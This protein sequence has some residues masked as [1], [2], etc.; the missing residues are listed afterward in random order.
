MNTPALYILYG[1]DD[2]GN[3]LLP[4]YWPWEQYVNWYNYFKEV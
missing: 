1:Q 2:F 4:A 3:A